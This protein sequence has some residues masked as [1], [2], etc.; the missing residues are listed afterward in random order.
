MLVIAPIALLVITGFI[1]LMVTMVGDA[2]VSRS[3]NVMT[4]DVQSA[5]SAIERDVR[6][7]TEFLVT[8]S[9]LPSPQG[10]NG[11]TSAFTATSG[12]LVL[13]EIATDKNPID[14][15]RSFVHY[16]TPNS[17]SSDNAYQNRIFFT[18]V[19]YT[20][21]DGSLWRRTY[22]PAPSGTLCKTAWQINTCAP[23]YS[24][25]ATQCKANDSEI[26]KNVKTFNVE[27]FINPE[28]TVALSPASATDASSI[29]VTIE[30]EQSSA[31]RT[32]NATS[33][34]RSTKLTSKEINL[35]PPDAPVVTGSTSGTDAVFSWPSVPTASSYIIKYNINGGGWKTATE[36]STETTFSLPANHGDT[37]SVQVMSRNTTGASSVASASTTIP[38]WN[39]CGLMNGWVNYHP[40]GAPSHVHCGFT[41]TKHGVVMLKGLIKDGPAGSST[42]FNLPP[43]YRPSQ[44]L[45]FNAY[46]ASGNPVRIN[47]DANGD[48]T[49]GR[50]TG[51]S[52][53]SAYVS[54]DNI[55]FI[56][57]KS[58]YTR[59]LITPQ[60]GWTNYA[61]TY[62][63]SL[64]SIEDASGRIHVQGLVVPGTVTVGTTIGTIPGG[65]GTSNRLFTARSQGGGRPNGFV[66]VGI[67]SP[68]NVAARGDAA[69][70]YYSI[71]LMYHPSTYTSWQSFTPAVAGNPA[72]GQ[73]GNGWVNYSSGW[74]PPQYTKAPD[75][76]VSLRGLVS[77][78]TTT[79]GTLIARLPPGYRPKGYLIFYTAQYPNTWSRI[80][81]NS[82][83]YIISN[84]SNSTWTSLDGISFM[85]EE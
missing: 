39:E 58:S 1:A 82:N 26:L 15:T 60:N 84:M 77:G 12:D 79:S 20:V 41:M 64:Q 50:E 83:G 8:T 11:A 56:P 73:L 32:V 7:S 51:D 44:R 29:R 5:L 70:T 38:L 74:G 76:I 62:H 59:T 85:A 63:S 9:T 2:I 28:D 6:L 18:T 46:T 30:T 23:G 48:I 31:G 69:G 54:L 72:D 35:A 21:R 66:H 16:N 19:I 40:T 13:G 42:L 34:G 52:T 57:G 61:G 45:I 81:V 36:N 53:S 78:G 43:D 49:L 47:V 4:Y 33:A 3:Q 10:K 25:S 37:I 14:P 80:D 68:G 75:N 17:C 27:Y 24:S 67:Y 71:Q 65:A 55:H 22:V